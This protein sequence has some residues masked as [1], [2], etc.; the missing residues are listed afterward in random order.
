MSTSTERR[1]RHHLQALSLDLPGQA[2]FRAASSAVLVAFVAVFAVL[3][4]CPADGAVD[5]L[6]GGLAGLEKAASRKVYTW[7]HY[8]N[9]EQ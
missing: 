5:V 6:R 7:A 2:S 3:S 8:C 4:D 1:G 9:A